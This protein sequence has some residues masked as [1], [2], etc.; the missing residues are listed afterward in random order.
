V[1]LVFL[2]SIQFEASKFETRTMP[3]PNMK[4]KEM[5]YW[6][7]VETQEK[8]LVADLENFLKG[9]SQQIDLR[10]PSAFI[11]A[12]VE[13]ENSSSIY[14]QSES[15]NGGRGESR[16]LEQLEKENKLGEAEVDKNYVIEIILRRTLP[17]QPTKQSQSPYG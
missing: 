9:A 11:T 4:G 2:G 6:I 10:V 5:I 7:R 8:R 12:K 17:D 14:D 13:L 1:V 15:K 3:T 16:P